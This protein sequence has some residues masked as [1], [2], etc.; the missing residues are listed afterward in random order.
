MK[1][2]HVLML[3][4]WPEAEAEHHDDADVVCGHCP[5]HS[6]AAINISVYDGEIELGQANIAIEARVV[7]WS[8][9]ESP[10]PEGGCGVPTG[11]LPGALGR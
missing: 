1:P 9:H 10:V 8:G 7:E 4:A 3:P 11:I 6:D 2:A 5:R